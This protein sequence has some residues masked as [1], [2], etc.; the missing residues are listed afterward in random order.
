VAS[1]PRSRW[2]RSDDILI[3]QTTA[4]VH[5][6]CSSRS[7]AVVSARMLLAAWCVLS[8][9]RV[10]G[11]GCVLVA[12]AAFVV[13]ACSSTADTP[14]AV[15]LPNPTS[16]VGAVTTAAAATAVTQATGLS[17]ETEPLEID[18]LSPQVAFAGLGIDPTLEVIALADSDIAQLEARFRSDERLAP[19]LLGVD[20]KAIRR[21]G[22]L[23]AVGLS[24]GVSPDALAVPGFVDSFI[25]GATQ[26][27]VV[28]PLPEPIGPVELTTWLADD[29]GSFLWQHE[30][31]FIVLSGRDLL[32]VRYV[33]EAVIAGVLDLDLSEIRPVEDIVDTTIDT[34]DAE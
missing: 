26:G 16:I 20:A 24:V 29:A 7:L 9:T 2:R 12:S 32:D 25:D 13:A 11:S 33:A 30:N 14:Q 3:R 18:T 6:L 21:N 23:I 4:G 17:G 22:A 28:N 27:G 34:T 5:L 1:Q 15:L 19:F 31:L 10:R 8:R